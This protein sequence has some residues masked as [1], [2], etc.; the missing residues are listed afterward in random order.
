MDIIIK[1]TARFLE[2]SQKF[3]ISLDDIESKVK[4][5]GNNSGVSQ[6][7][8][9]N[10]SVKTVSGILSTEPEKTPIQK[11]RDKIE[12]VYSKDIQLLKEFEEYQ[13]LG[14]ELRNY[15]N[16]LIKVSNERI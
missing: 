7:V 13:T 10:S 1:K 3:S 9:T 4:K 2:L 6:W 5:N 8:M 12:D 16:S 11:L 15:Y 14:E